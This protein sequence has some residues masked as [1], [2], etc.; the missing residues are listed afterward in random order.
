MHPSWYR[1]SICILHSCDHLKGRSILRTIEH[2][3]IEQI[4]FFLHCNLPFAHNCG[5]Q[6][7]PQIQ[8][9]FPK[10]HIGP[11]HSSYWDISWFFHHSSGG[12]CSLVGYFYLW[13][14]SQH[15]HHSLWVFWLLLHLQLSISHL[16]LVLLTIITRRWFWRFIYKNCRRA[17]ISPTWIHLQIVSNARVILYEYHVSTFII[18]LVCKHINL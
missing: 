5:S 18:F 7:F 9:M 3:Q 11:F 8:R 1:I 13:W 12:H 10:C 4:V 17:F 14:I 16:L 2:E 6:H 15:D